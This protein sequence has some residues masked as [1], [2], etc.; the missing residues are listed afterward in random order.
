M[1]DLQGIT[2]FSLQL[3]EGP[4]E[5]AASPWAGRVHDLSCLLTDFS[6]TA[7]VMLELDL[8]ISVDTAVAHLA[9]AL[10]RPAW[11]LLPAVGSDWRWG[12]SG[13]TTAWYPSVRLF[14]QRQVGAWA[15]I[16]AEMTAL[17]T[18]PRDL[19]ETPRAS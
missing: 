7:A 14:R 15:P 17:L 8:L 9:G 19:P 4:P 11:I 12:V 2:W 6:A 10:G 5:L 1:L 13:E 16:A 3:G 18:A